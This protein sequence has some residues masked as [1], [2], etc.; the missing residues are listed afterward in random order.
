LP[1]NSH[2]PVRVISACGRSEVMKSPKVGI[3]HTSAMMI[4]AIV[5]PRLVRRRLVRFAVWPR[6]ASSIDPPSVPGTGRSTGATL[7]LISGSPSAA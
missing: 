3:V 2:Q 7:V 4:D 5:A 1:K 6:S